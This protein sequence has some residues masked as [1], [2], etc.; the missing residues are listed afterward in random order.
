MSAI[1]VMSNPQTSI[2]WYFN[3]TCQFELCSDNSTPSPLTNTLQMATHL[4]VW[5]PHR[6]SKVASILQSRTSV[7]QL[8]HQTNTNRIPHSSL[9][10]FV[11]SSGRL[12]GLVVE[13]VRF[14]NGH[15]LMQFL[16]YPWQQDGG[17]G[18]GGGEGG[19]KR[20][21]E[22]EMQSYLTIAG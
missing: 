9:T 22:R 20:E 13:L 18:G 16:G 10:L 1:V 14:S 6:L 2:E 17:G 8:T 5:F 21:E 15:I 12:Q 11:E 4:M 3:L 7:P 19:R